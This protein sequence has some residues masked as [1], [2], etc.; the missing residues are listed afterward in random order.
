MVTFQSFL[1]A[2]DPRADL[3]HDGMIN[4]LDIRMFQDALST[5]CQ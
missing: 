3:N 5:G 1:A 4:L 2:G